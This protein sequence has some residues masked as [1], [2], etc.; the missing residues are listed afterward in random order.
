MNILNIEMG[1][2]S[3]VDMFRE[4][5]LRYLIPYVLLLLALAGLGIWYEVSYITEDSWPET[6]MSIGQG[7]S[8][9]VAVTFTVFAAVEGTVYM[10]IAMARLRKLRE[11]HEERQEEARKKGLEEGREA[12]RKEGREA[13]REEG[14]E[15]G[16]EEGRKAERQRWEAWAKRAEEARAAGLPFDEPP[17]PPQEQPSSN[18]SA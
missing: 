14:R 5:D 4:Y 16:L 6:V 7:I 13:G 2:P 1:W 10:V 11:E 18:H 15:A 12:G 3:G 9:A 17:P 8:S